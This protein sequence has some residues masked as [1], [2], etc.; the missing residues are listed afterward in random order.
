MILSVSRRTDIPSF[1]MKWFIKRLD[2][3]FLLVRNPLFPNKVSRVN[4]IKD[5]ID[6]IVFWTKNPGSFFEYVDF[7]EDY[8]YY[9]QVT[10]NDYPEYIEPNLPSIG[11]RINDFVELSKRLGSDKLVW[12]Y[13]PI[14][15]SAEVDQDY[16]LK[17][18]EKIC[19]HLSSHTDTVMISILDEYPRIKG[20][21]KEI[22]KTDFLESENR[23]FLRKLSE[24]A[25]RYK[26]K[27]LSCAETYDFADLDILPGKCIDDK[28]IEKITGK[29]LV[30]QKD[31]AQRTECNC[32]E[33]IDIGSYNTCTHG[34][35]Y[36]Y[37]NFSSNSITQNLRRYNEESPILCDTISESD[38]II[39]RKTRKIKSLPIQEILDL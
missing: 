39:E 8:N 37:A 13:D 1:F 35:T 27:M 24:V 31:K 4:L 19:E 3:G 30:V 6:F 12:R 22:A 7:F 36:C 9:L 25:I 18:F 26:I 33:S 38:Q 15:Y 11:K 5:E 10:L 29:R 32:I 20:R 28:R 16:H 17:H 34:C 2:E 23:A 14:F 21:I